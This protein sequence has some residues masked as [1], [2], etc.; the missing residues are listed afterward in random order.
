MAC[1]VLHN[2]A[3]HHDVDMDDIDEPGAPENEN[4]QHVAYHAILEN[5]RYLSQ[6]GQQER[7]R[8]IDNVFAFM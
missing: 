1:A 6:L 5:G 2:I 8:L 3:K 7:Q 4:D